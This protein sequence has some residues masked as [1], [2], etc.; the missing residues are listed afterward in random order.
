M[1]N[2]PN[3]SLEVVKVDGIIDDVAI[4]EKP[5]EKLIAKIDKRRKNIY[6]DLYKNIVNPK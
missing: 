2:K 3:D 6:P 4:P 1:L 5:D